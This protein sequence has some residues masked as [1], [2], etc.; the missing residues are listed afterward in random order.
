IVID[1]MEGVC[2]FSLDTTV[3]RNGS[4]IIF[5]AS[6]GK[7]KEVTLEDYLISGDKIIVSDLLPESGQI[8]T[9]G[10]E[11]LFE[12]IQISVVN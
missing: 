2:I 8:I 3:L 6:N 10:Q 12:G 5:L 7:A 4:R 9:A 1:K 11:A